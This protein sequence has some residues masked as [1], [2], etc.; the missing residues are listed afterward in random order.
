[1]SFGSRAGLNDYDSIRAYGGD[2]DGFDLDFPVSHSTGFPPPSQ[3]QPVDSL[4]SCQDPVGVAPSTFTIKTGHSGRDTVE[5]ADEAQNN[6]EDMLRVTHKVA[7]NASGVREEIP[8]G[9]MTALLRPDLM[10]LSFGLELRQT[11]VHVVH[12]LHDLQAKVREVKRNDDKAAELASSKRPKTAKEHVVYWV[13]VICR[14][15]HTLFSSL[16][17]GLTRAHDKSVDLLG[18]VN[19]FCSAKY[20]KMCETA[21]AYLGD[22]SDSKQSLFALASNGCRKLLSWLKNLF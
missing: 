21:N 3:Q 1:M 19:T 12:F 2:Y 6:M 14:V 7:S 5:P 17:T 18:R 8:T 9:I 22:G 16:Y 13:S 10:I 15:V 20:T 4:A 11:Q